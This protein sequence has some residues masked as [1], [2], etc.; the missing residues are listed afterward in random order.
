MND[1]EDLE[2][3]KCATCDRWLNSDEDLPMDCDDCGN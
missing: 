1:Q 3:M 2:N